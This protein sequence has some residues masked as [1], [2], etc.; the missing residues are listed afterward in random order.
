MKTVKYVCPHC[1]RAVEYKR[2]EKI[3]N[4]IYSSFGPVLMALGIFMLFYIWIAGTDTILEDVIQGF[5]NKENIKVDDQLRDIAINITKDC[6]TDRSKCF[7]K[8]MY[9]NISQI[10]YVPTSINKD[11]YD[12]LYVYHYGGDCKNTANMFVALLGSVGVRGKIKCSIK[13]NHCISELYDT[14]GNERLGGKFV[15]DL[16]MPIAVYMNESEDAWNYLDY[17]SL[18]W[19]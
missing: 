5:Y 3:I 1:K 19:D 10:R 2:G 4:F 13:E 9:Q 8:T 11:T 12:P 17:K 7:I 6:S 18:D 14:D 15:I 16:T